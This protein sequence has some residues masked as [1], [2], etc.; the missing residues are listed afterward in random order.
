MNKLLDF[1]QINTKLDLQPCGT[2]IH[3]PTLHEQDQSINMVAV[4]QK[5]FSMD[6]ASKEILQAISQVVLKQSLLKNPSELTR[7]V[8]FTSD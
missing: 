1:D 5:V 4:N 2:E 8:W 6:M 3:N 7:Q